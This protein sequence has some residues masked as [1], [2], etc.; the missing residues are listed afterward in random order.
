MIQSKIRIGL[1]GLGFGQKVH[2]PALRL[3]E[4]CEVAG[5][6]GRRLAQTKEAAERLGIDRAYAHWT[7]LVHDEDID[8]VTIAV[9]PARQP[10][11]A[12]AALAAGK[13]VFC[14]KP[15][16]MTGEQVE[17][18]VAAAHASDL[19]HMIDFE[20]PEISVWKQARTVLQSGEIGQLRH[21]TVKW[22]VQA[23]ARPGGQNGC[24]K[25]RAH[26]GGGV[27]NTF[28]SHVLHYLQWLAGDVV[29]LSAR[30]M[31]GNEEADQGDTLALMHV[32]F[33]S[34]ALALVSLS[35]HSM[36]HNRHRVEIFGD[37]GRLVLENTALDYIDGFRLFCHPENSPESE[38]TVETAS[39]RG[40]GRVVVVGRLFHRFLDWI[41]LG[42]PATPDFVE[43]ARVQALL[44]AARDSDAQRDWVQ[45]PEFA[46][47]E[48]TFTM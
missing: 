18:M 20:C 22:D 47:I 31:M 32:E 7:E 3:D 10:E 35:Q 34:G 13:A 1:V 44:D 37:Q 23:P 25:G 9:E 17:A 48:H 19:A 2:V 16:G 29:R 39:H 6:C 43:G 12:L 14:E 46:R 40:D 41:E 42:A 4:R 38:M 11:I 28:G 5:V 33:A 8:A 27:L 21:L 30:L 15:L 26:L 36:H 24:W 45:V